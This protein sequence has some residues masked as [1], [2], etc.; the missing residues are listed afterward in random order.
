MAQEDLVLKER[1]LHGF[2]RCFAEKKGILERSQGTVQ[3]CKV[4]MVVEGA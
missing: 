3:G 2:R 1:L 4:S